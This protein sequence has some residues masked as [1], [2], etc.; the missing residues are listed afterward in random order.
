MS[1]GCSATRGW[2]SNRVEPRRRRQSRSAWE[3]WISARVLSWRSSAAETSRP[4][5]SHG[6]S[7]RSNDLA[8]GGDCFVDRRHA[9][10]ELQFVDRLQDLAHSRSWRDAEIEQVPSQQDRRRLLVLDAERLGAFEEPLD[11]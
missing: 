9:A 10:I 6:T 3:M 11:S 1:A 8:R 5:R 7:T 2:S 4:R